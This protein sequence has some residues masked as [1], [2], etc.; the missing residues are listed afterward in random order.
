MDTVT[1]ELSLT[2]P[3]AVSSRA[4]RLSTTMRR[5]APRSVRARVA[6]P[7]SISMTDSMPDT[8]LS[9]ATHASAMASSASARWSAAHAA[10]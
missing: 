4:L 8:L 3:K 7:G 2:T 6:W 9:S 5:M 10:R 1:N